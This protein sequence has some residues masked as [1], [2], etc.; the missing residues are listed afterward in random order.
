MN[1]IRIVMAAGMAAIALAAL[2]T[3]DRA[4]AATVS[5][6]ASWSNAGPF[7]NDTLNLQK[8]NTGLGTLTGVQLTLSGVADL[9]VNVFNFA[10]GAWSGT[11]SDCCASIVLT[12]LGSDTTSA[13]L[14][15]TG[16]MSVSGTGP[17]FSTTYFAGPNSTS[18]SASVAALLGELSLYEGAGT[19]AVSL[20][21]DTTTSTWSPTTGG[22]AGGGGASGSGTVTVEYTYAPLATPLPAA[23][24]LFASGLGALGLVGWRKKRKSSAAV[25]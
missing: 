8:F 3:P 24:P 9:G 25:A 12:G 10:G 14:T 13:A 18:L 4:Y 15:A 5:Y 16:L 20:L 1:N 6:N 2:G 22:T 21:V 19:F 11:G 7:L 17:A 23:L